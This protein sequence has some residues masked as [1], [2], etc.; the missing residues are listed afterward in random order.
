MKHI[1]LFSGGASSSYMAWLVAQEVSKEDIVLLHTPTGAEHPDADRF[2]QEVADYIG[3]E[4]TEVSSGLNLW[5]CIIKNNCLPSQFIPFC[6]RVLKVE[7]AEKYYKELL[8]QGE[9]FIIYVGFGKQ[10]WRRLQRQATRFKTKGYKVKY[11]LYEKKLTSN[12]CKEIIKNEWKICLPEPYKILKHNNC[13]PCFKGGK[14]HFYKVWK[15]YP[16]EFKK[17]VDMEEL[18][19]NTVFKD[20]SLLEL[21]EKWEREDKWDDKQ[22]KLFPDVENL[23]SM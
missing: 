22:L 16:E 2:R 5:K 17:A 20:C 21:V 3:I 14:K 10:E 6:T 13:I 9:D 12:I 11:P 1:I 23:P 4:I 7:P 18:I 8:L 19:G 15:Y